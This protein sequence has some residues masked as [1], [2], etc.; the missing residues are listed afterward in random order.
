VSF[1]NDSSTKERSA[2]VLVGGGGHCEVVI[3]I[4]REENLYDEIII[5][6][7]PENLGKHISEAIYSLILDQKLRQ[8]FS[9]EAQRKAKIFSIERCA[10]NHIRMYEEIL[11]GKV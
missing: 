2:I 11:N 10:E 7:L 8:K 1:E 4:I 5:S 6:D 9:I 3:D